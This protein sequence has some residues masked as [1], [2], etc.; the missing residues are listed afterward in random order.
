MLGR[1][2]NSPMECASIPMPSHPTEQYKRNE[3][4]DLKK[5]MEHL[6][7]FKEKLSKLHPIVADVIEKLLQHNRY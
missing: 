1:I 7:E 5:G 2:G 4:D 6:Y 3:L